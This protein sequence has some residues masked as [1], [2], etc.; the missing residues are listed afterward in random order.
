MVVQESM[1]IALACSHWASVLIARS[2]DVAEGID[3]D[4]VVPKEGDN[5][6]NDP[7]GI[8]SIKCMRASKL[9]IG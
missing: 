9:G 4:S 8:I 1:T 2:V 6:G 5:S 7:T 3:R